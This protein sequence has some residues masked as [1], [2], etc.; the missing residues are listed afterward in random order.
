MSQET[1]EAPKIYSARDLMEKTFP[2]PVYV[3]P[4]I[5]TPGMT[6]LAA[7]PKE[8]KSWLA[9]QWALTVASGTDTLDVLTADESLTAPREPHGVLYLALEDHEA[10]FQSRLAMLWGEQEMPDGFDYSLDWP[11]M[12]EGGD[13]ALSDYLGGHPDVKLVVIDT[14]EHVRKPG[15]GNNMYAEDVAAL[16][17]LKKL[18][19]AFPAIALLV[20]H[21]LR[22]SGAEDPLD[23]L[24]GSTG[25]TGTADNILVLERKHTG[26]RETAT[27]DITGRNI[28][29]GQLSLLFDGASCRWL[30]GIDLSLDFSEKTASQRQLLQVLQ[31]A[32]EPLQAK[33]INRR[34]GLPPEKVNT[35]AVTLTRLLQYGLL[36]RPS[37]G[38]YSLR[39]LTAPA[40]FPEHSRDQ[41]SYKEGVNS[42]NIS[43]GLGF[44]SGLTEGAV[45]KNGVKNLNGENSGLRG[46]LNRFNTDERD[47]KEAFI[48]SVHEDYGLD[49]PEAKKLLGCS[50][51]NVTD[52]DQARETLNAKL[53]R[54]VPVLTGD[55]LPSVASRATARR[56]E[57]ISEA[58]R[59]RTP[60]RTYKE[61]NPVPADHTCTS[62]CRKQCE[63]DAA[64]A[65]EQQQ[66]DLQEWQQAWAEEE[67]AYDTALANPAP[68]P[69][70]V[71][72]DWDGTPV[73]F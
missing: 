47:V 12:H 4:G 14:L 7:K 19:D 15:T 20:I 40:S 50:P 58:V 25:V 45:V 18:A 44:K 67:L 60:S 57:A 33:E 13:V 68:V 35:T 5:L 6:I 36:D 32:N 34:A 17:P 64:R 37:R 26:E 63:K 43:S 23:R 42:V 52:Y 49:L 59:R 30:P 16:R 11:R 71:A 10:S 31:A 65:K 56:Q 1:R 27:L 22:K 2:P 21:H 41:A 28:E 54:P 51:A 61:R 9:Q 69:V 48:T 72:A 66:Q 70:A 39:K 55:P 38:H 8:G 53:G 73:T 3:L 29:E 46:T 24:T 62:S